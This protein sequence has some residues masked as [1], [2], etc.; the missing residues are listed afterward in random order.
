MTTYR[1]PSSSAASSD[2]LFLT[3]VQGEMGQS[4]EVFSWVEDKSGVIVLG[5]T[6]LLRDF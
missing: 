1:V 5:S 2:G 4:F 3:Q 6:T